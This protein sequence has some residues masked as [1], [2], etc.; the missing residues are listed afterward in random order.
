MQWSK[1]IIM[2]AT[3]IGILALPSLAHAQHGMGRFMFR[4]M[5]G[6][7]S[8]MGMNS[9][10]MNSGVMNTNQ[11]LVNQ[12]LMNQRLLVPTV[13]NLGFN[14]SFVNP[15]GFNSFAGLIKPLGFNTNQLMRARLINSLAN[16]R[17]PF[18]TT[19][20]Q[21]LAAE[22]A[23][24]LEFSSGLSPFAFAPGLWPG[25]SYGSYNIPDYAWGGPR[26][27]AAATE[28]G[29]YDNQLDPKRITIRVGDTLQWKNYS[30]NEHSIVSDDGLWDSGDLR[31][32]RSF[33]FTFTDTGV[34]PFH[35]ANNPL[36]YG[37]VE[38]RQ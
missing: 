29:V 20:A 11:A 23:A 2:A 13:S 5:F 4:P 12:A 9:M 14:R 15:L 21:L 28:I 3:L 24:A 33:R 7:N 35:D 26:Q 17:S 34:Y 1:R 38:V 25:Y 31:K 37:T 36:L 30:K 19:Q 10:P 8:A 16:G 32:G 18:A 22:S 27:A 6:M